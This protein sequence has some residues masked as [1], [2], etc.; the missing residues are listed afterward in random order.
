MVSN[1]FF[2]SLELTMQLPFTIFFL[3]HILAIKLFPTDH[4]FFLY[5]TL[6]C[7]EMQSSN[8]KHKVFIET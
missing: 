8:E 5:T 1:V 6:N 3:L 7:M 4:A 2:I